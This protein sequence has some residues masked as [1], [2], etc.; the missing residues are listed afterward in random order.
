MFRKLFRSQD[1]KNVQV[2]MDYLLNF[3][4]QRLVGSLFAQYSGVETVIA[5]KRK[6]GLDTLVIAVELLAIALSDTIEKARLREHDRIAIEEFVVGGIGA[7][8]DFGEA[9]R[10]FLDNCNLQRNLKKID[11]HLYLYAITEVV[12]ALRELDK[13]ERSNQRILSALEKAMFPSGH[14]ASHGK[15]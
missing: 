7:G 9:L 3:G 12:G 5:A 13:D 4:H 10:A 8:T 2:S 15:E 11:D 1:S 14:P 6:E